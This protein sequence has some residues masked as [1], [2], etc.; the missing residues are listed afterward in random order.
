MSPFFFNTSRAFGE[1]AITFKSKRG[2]VHILGYIDHTT[3]MQTTCPTLSCS[4]NWQ[5]CHMHV[6][7][8]QVREKGA[9]HHELP[10]IDGIRVN[11]GGTST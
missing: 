10:L 7:E 11:G 3:G 5:H 8:E 9:W 2:I 1:S 6:N 4:D